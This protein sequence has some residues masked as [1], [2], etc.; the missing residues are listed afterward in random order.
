MKLLFI[1]RTLLID[2]G[3]ASKRTRGQLSG[4]FTEGGSPPFNRWNN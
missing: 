2:C 4:P 3:T 1:A